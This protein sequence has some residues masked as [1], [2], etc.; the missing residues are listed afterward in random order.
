MAK[1]LDVVMAFLKQEEWPFEI[2]EN[3]T[4]ARLHFQGDSAQ[5]TCFAQTREE[6][7]QFVFYS[8]CPVNVPEHKRMEIAEFITRA[9]YD[10]AIGNFEMDFEDG[11]V[12]FKTS[13]DVEGTELSLELL[14]PL[15]YANVLM[16]DQYLPGLM[17]VI[18]SDVSPATAVEQV[19]SGPAE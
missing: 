8:V 4:V 19:E 6:V 13:I 18:Y 2:L 16:M 11:E 10:M 1:L 5:F 12:R 9:N 14:N 15:L 7:N 17:S 3:S